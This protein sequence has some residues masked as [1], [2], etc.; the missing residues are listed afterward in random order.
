M[1]KLFLVLSL[2]G[3]AAEAQTSQ[4]GF[5]LQTDFSY[6]QMSY[7]ESQGAES[8]GFLAG[9]RLE[10][11]MSLTGGARLGVSGRYSAGHL[12]YK[13][14]TWLDT[15]VAE[16]SR[17]WVR[18]L[19]AGL[20]LGPSSSNLFIGYA[21]RLWSAKLPES[22]KRESSIDYL[23]I[24]FSAG[25][26]GFFLAGEYRHWIKGS[27]ISKLSAVDPARSD[28]EVEQE[29]GSGFAAEVGYVFASQAVATRLAITYEKWSVDP[30]STVSDGIDN[31]QIPENE[32]T[33]LG[34]SIGISL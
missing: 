5:Q 30:S 19:R 25:A 9:A 27:A 34:F 11:L 2:V 26:G 31:Q 4:V 7:K 15:D 1:R 24:R 3:A 29:K 28:V 18:D 14:D 16:L 21:Q 10:L 8:T 32:T 6:T 20:Y 33:L 17:D 22:F 23:P 12:N 13:G